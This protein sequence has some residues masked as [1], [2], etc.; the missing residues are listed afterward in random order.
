MTELYIPPPGIPFRLLGFQSNFVLY[1]RKIDEPQFH[2]FSQDPVSADQYFQL[3][4]GTGKFK[5]YYLI[6]GQVTGYYIFS[7]ID[8][9]GHW[10]KP[11]GVDVNEDNYFKLEPGSGKTAGKFRLVNFKSNTVIYSRSTA[12]PQ[13]GVFSSTSDKFD[14]QYFS[15]LFSD[16]KIEKIDLKVDICTV[17]RNTPIIIATKTLRNGSSASQSTEFTVDRK[18]ET[19]ST[20]EYRS[21][22]PLK[23]GDSGSARIPLIYE[24]KVEASATISST[25]VWGSPHIGS[26][27]WTGK[28]LVNA[29]PHKIAR[30]F[31][32]ATSSTV[33]IPVIIRSKSAST[34][35]TAETKA[36]YH[37][38]LVWGQHYAVTEKDYTA[39]YTTF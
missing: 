14:D 25:F 33:D 3:I 8:S 12:A 10:E 31:V 22:L 24:G 7:R 23:A 38:V 37:A 2:H 32:Y 35:Q 20:F 1:S 17:T 21:G 36:T 18:T 11:A 4:P 30:S 27:T 16:M 26:D 39:E 29:A 34:G 9:F 5:D 19:S 13:V 6:Q 28:F 15:F